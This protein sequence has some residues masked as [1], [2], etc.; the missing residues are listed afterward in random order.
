MLLKNPHNRI[1]SSEAL[2][3]GYF[4]ELLKNNQ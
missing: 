2:R 1:S 3:H 4:K